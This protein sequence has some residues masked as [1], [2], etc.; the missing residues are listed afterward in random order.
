MKKREIYILPLKIT[1]YTEYGSLKTCLRG[2]FAGSMLG[3]L[4]ALTCSVIQDQFEAYI[5]GVSLSEPHTR[6]LGGE[7]SVRMLVIVCM[8]VSVGL[9]ARIRGKMFAWSSQMQNNCVKK[10][11]GHA[12][13]SPPRSDLLSAMYTHAHQL[14]VQH[15]V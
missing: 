10:S 7:I 12:I 15:I 1:T 4:S 14:Q 5:I 11:Q 6:E 9:R 2:M 3:E 8:L 13:F